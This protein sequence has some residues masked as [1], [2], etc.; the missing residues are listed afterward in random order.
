[1]GNANKPANN[2]KIGT[3]IAFLDTIKKQPNICM[4][5]INF[6][7]G[8]HIATLVILRDTLL[9]NGYIEKNEING[10]RTDLMITLKGRKLLNELKDLR[11]R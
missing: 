2:F 5:R 4:L 3:I 10:R 11:K 1:M 8:L 6:K 9:R 7:T